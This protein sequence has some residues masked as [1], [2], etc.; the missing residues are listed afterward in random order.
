M[1][2]YHSSTLCFFIINKRVFYFTAW[3]HL[4]VLA[5]PERIFGHFFSTDLAFTGTGTIKATDA[6]SESTFWQDRAVH[7]E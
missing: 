3:A 1:A 4:I 7:Q 2:N 5:Q 6:I